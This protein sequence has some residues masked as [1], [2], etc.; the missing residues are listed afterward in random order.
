[1]QKLA[2]GVVMLVAGAAQAD[3][4]ADVIAQAR[5]I[6]D[7]T[8]QAYNAGDVSTLMAQLDRGFFGAGPSQGAQDADLAAARVTFEKEAKRGNQLVRDSITMR[9]DES[10]DVVWYI[11]E[12][13]IQPKTPPAGG[14]PPRKLRE[15]GV[16]VKRATGWKIAMW[17]AAL[18]M[19]D[20]EPGAPAK[21]AP[22]PP[23]RR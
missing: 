16:V 12:Y 5:A 8:D 22:T 15:S 1:M 9:A 21:A 2:I 18:P 7:K 19:A 11:A 23:P 10:G 13:T 6:V 4:T 14:G 3:K 17:H 20:R